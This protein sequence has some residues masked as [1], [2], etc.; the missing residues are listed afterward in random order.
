MLGR[1]VELEKRVMWLKI[2]ED[3]RSVDGAA[4]ELV[5]GDAPLHTQHWDPREFRVGER[6]TATL[7]SS[8][9]QKTVL[10]SISS[11]REEREGRNG[12]ILQ[13]T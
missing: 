10:I 5:V 3:V 8:Q 13:R 6:N 4:A 1:D 12:R 7:L 9:Y 11:P 2:C